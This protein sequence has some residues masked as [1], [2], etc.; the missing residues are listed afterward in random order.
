MA[1]IYEEYVYIQPMF[2]QLLIRSIGQMSHLKQVNEISFVDTGIKNSKT[3]YLVHA[4]KV[5]SNNLF[6]SPEPQAH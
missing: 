3:L 5:I 6:I 2:L 1:K 4:C